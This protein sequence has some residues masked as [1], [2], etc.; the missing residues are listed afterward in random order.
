MMEIRVPVADA[1]R[2]DRLVG[3]LAGLFDQECVSFD[4]VRHEVAVRSEW[5]SRDV[6]QVIDAIGSWLTSNGGGS[7]MLSVGDRQYSL[8]GSACLA[9]AS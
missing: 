2:A 5:E 3:Q 6:G 8:N 7:A 4:G 9:V 1:V